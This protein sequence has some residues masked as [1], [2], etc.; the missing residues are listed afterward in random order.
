MKGLQLLYRQNIPLTFD[1]GMYQQ[2]DGV[3]MGSPLGPVLGGIIVVELEKYMVAKLKD[4]L[5]FWKRY[6]ED[7]LTFLGESSIKY[8]LQEL[9][10]FHPDIQL[11]YKLEMKNKIFR[12]SHYSQI[13][14]I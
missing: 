11:M 14:H 3:A 9:N 6:A 2:S 8:L 12:C 7:T 5:C 13:S 4:N 10:F 1:N